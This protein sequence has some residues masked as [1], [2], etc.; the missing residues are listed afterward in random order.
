[1]SFFNKVLASVGIGSAKV[2]TKLYKERY[3]VGEE[4]KGIVEITGGNLEQPIDEIYLSLATTYIK[5]SDDKKYTQT[6]VI[7]KFRVLEKLT[8]A[9]NEVREIPFS[10]NLPLN[11]PL[12]MGRTRIWIQ[13]GLDIKNAIDPSDKDFIEVTPLPLVASVLTAVSELGFR[14]R[15][16]ECEEAPRYLRGSHLFVQ[17]FE[18]VPTG[19]A[20]R[21]KLD[22]LELTFFPKSESTVEII[23]QVDRRARGLGGLFS[24]A[25]A[26]DE[27]NVRLTVNENDIPTMGNKIFDVIKRYS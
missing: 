18:F 2:D 5:E 20:F 13:T 4:V 7:N 27:S 19:G 1:M 10:F 22:E 21:G 26:M 14:L 25:L 11:T 9:P 17:E 15:E 24:E 23:M 12:S 6:G 16:V 3:V 8:I